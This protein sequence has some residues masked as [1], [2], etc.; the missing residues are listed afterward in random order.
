MDKPSDKPEA[1]KVYRV[2]PAKA[3]LKGYRDNVLR[4]EAL[5][6]ALG[7]AEQTMS[8]Y[9]AAYSRATRATSRIKA[10]A[11]SGTGAHDGLANA[12]MEMIRWQGDAIKDAQTADRLRATLDVEIAHAADALACR[13]M[14]IDR[15][16]DERYKALLTMRYI[17][18]D[19]WERICEVMHYEMRWVFI[20]HG[21]ALC[22][23]QALMK[24]VQ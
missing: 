15:L 16:S 9:D 1:V 19:S 5:T 22:E 24:T 17:S 21:K 3:Y 4:I 12:V 10:V 20:L 2:N 13:L 11:I 18:G 7:R 23:I 14:L 6:R 8:R